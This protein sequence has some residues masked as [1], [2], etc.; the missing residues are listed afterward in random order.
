MFRYESFSSCVHPQK[1]E[2]SFK[3]KIRQIT[4]F[5]CGKSLNRDIQELNRYINYAMPKKMFTQKKGLVL[6][7]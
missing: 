3:D 5:N 6:L 4:R 2:K 1:T 7:G